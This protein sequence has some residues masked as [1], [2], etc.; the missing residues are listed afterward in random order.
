MWISLSDVSLGYAG[1]PLLEK[2]TFQLDPGDRLALCGRNGTGK[3]SLLA[4]LAN[5]LEPESGRVFRAPGSTVA[6]LR[7]SQAALPT[8]TL[9]D[10][11]L[12]P[13]ADLVRLEA[14]I[15]ELTAAMAQDPALAT[16]YGLLQDQFERRGGYSAPAQA[17]KVLSGLGFSDA[18]HAK[19]TGALS[20]GEKNRLALARLLLADAPVLL[21]DEPT[22]HL[23]VAATEFLEDFLA[24][25]RAGP[26]RAMVVVSHDRLFLDRVASRT[27]LIEAKRLRLFPGGYTRA[28]ALRAEQ[29]ALEARAF[30]Q[31]Q[32]HI[33]RTED[34]IQRNLAGQ[35]T[36]QA[37]SRRTQLQKLE[38]LERPTDE[39]GAAKIVLPTL[40]GSAREVLG[41]K[42]LS[43]T[44][45]ARTLLHGASFT[46]ERGE[47][48]ALVGPNGAGKTTLLR[49]L[50]GEASPSA[51]TVRLGAGVQVGYY[52]QALRGIE[53]HAT[54]LDA[55]RSTGKSHSF[56]VGK[57]RTAELA[58]PGS[59]SA[60]QDRR[61]FSD[62]LLRAW[63]GRFLFSGADALRPLADMSGGEQARAALAKLTL[64]G[65]NFLVL[66]EP[67]NHLDIASREALESA[68]TAYTGTLL[69]VSHDRHFL[70][71]TTSR[72]LWLDGGQLHDWPHP[73]G[74]ARARHLA[75]QKPGAA[76][77][78][79]GGDAQQAYEAQRRRDRELG[80]RKRRLTA[81]EGELGAL[82]EK[83]GAVEA[84]LGDPALADAW[85]K[86]AELH[87]GKDA[88]E[89]QML[90][91]MEEREALGT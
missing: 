10:A 62:E 7:Q 84:A 29:R 24:N 82:E 60:S 4:L 17:K 61:P 54:V 57:S 53:G 72:T 70:D 83:L 40:P 25:G 15:A 48:V 88:L 11:A 80:R 74:E 36:K 22:N 90:A 78:A 34:F 65:A 18:S 30:D 5:E 51:G 76:A 46:L 13:L 52:D 59:P 73:F 66:D 81:I 85:E 58:A 75:A 86:L 49:A 56:H 33:A 1:T 63:A 38:R 55:L 3:T 14:E 91:L 27:A 79:V 2:V 67:T 31:Q 45:G 42:D 26:Q 41:V 87:R 69:C 47:R 8:G 35:N 6:V 16:R 12:E 71:R 64:Q 19:P 50:I 77:G 20:G 39:R 21:L 32:A 43:L 37:Q 68:L 28:T 44:V 89:E 23:D 9:L